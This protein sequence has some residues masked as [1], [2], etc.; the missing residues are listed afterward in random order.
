VVSTG[1]SSVV[2]DAFGI[3]HYGPGA[4]SINNEITETVATDSGGANGIWFFAAYNTVVDDN[5]I[6]CTS[7]AISSAY[8]IYMDTSSNVM[9]VN[10]RIVTADY[11]VYYSSS[12]GKYH[13]N[14]TDGVTTAYTGGTAVGTNN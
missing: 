1:G 12:T 5:R 7:S 6:S 8:G 9:V 13:D 14:I 10:N 11:G 3:V 4:R 2:I